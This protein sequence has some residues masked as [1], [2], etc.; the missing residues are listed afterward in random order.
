MG[1]DVRLITGEV[2]HDKPVRW[3]IGVREL[4]WHRITS[5]GKA[6]AG[7]VASKTPAAIRAFQPMLKLVELAVVSQVANAKEKPKVVADPVAVIPRETT[8][9]TASVPRI[10][11]IDGVAD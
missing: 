8:A 9:E 7:I 11:P 6:T 10:T 5:E 1:I 2:L 4:A 3:P